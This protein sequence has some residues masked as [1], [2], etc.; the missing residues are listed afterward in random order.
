MNYP[1][2]IYNEIPSG[3]PDGSNPTF[4]LVSAPAPANSLQLY[5]NGILVTAETD[6]RLNGATITLFRP[7]VSGN[8]LRAY[9]Q[10]AGSQVAMTNYWQD[11][12]IPLGFIS[13]T[14]KIYTL[15]NVPT[16]STSLMF[17]RNGL[18]QQL[19][20]DYHFDGQQIIT[21]LFVPDTDDILLCYYQVVGNCLIAPSF[22]GQ[23]TVGGFYP[24]P[25]SGGSPYFTLQNP[26]NSPQSLQLYVNGLLQQYGVDY[27][28]NNQLVYFILR[29]PSSS[30]VIT[31]FYRYFNYT[32]CTCLPAPSFPLVSGEVPSGQIDGQNTIFTL[33]YSPSPQSSLI[34]TN[35][36]ITL[37]VNQDFI[38]YSNTIQLKIAPA[39]GDNLTAGYYYLRGAVRTQSL[40]KQSLI[41]YI[42]KYLNDP[43]GALWSNSTIQRFIDEAEVEVTQNVN[44]IWQ[45]FSLNI[46]ANQNTYT[47]PDNL[48]SITRMTWMSYAVN[49]LSQQEVS[50]L[51]PTYM[52]QVSSQPRWASMQ[53]E[54]YHVLRLYPGPSISLP[55]LSDQNTIYTDVN[56]LNEFVVSAYMYSE[57]YVPFIEIPDYFARKT[58]RYYVQW[59]CYSLEGIGLN[60]KLAAYY[61]AKFEAQNVMNQETISRMNSG[62][63][64]QYTD[65]AIQ[66]PWK[67]ARPILPPNFGTVVLMDS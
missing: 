47:L 40:V 39:I 16:P 36:G 65:I 2:F 45:R 21:T 31:A 58:L 5:W 61:K 30:D 13:P 4:T 44:I 7:A 19:G 1:N 67:R 22:S 35:R 59:K 56:I 37:Q 17:F 18:L 14:N 32:T 55:I 23:E 12:E 54:G 11:A 25:L 64:R 43:Q 20:Y 3:S 27:T 15:R 57:E 62:K 51:S 9:Y 8:I 48:K 24:L 46:I 29:I 66:R 50:L 52:T 26:P 33:L 53:F 28:L 38:L 63:K 60:P 42:R 6:Y 10:T 34:L 49:M 41:P